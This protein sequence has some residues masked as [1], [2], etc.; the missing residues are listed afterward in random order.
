MAKFS[1]DLIALG[2]KCDEAIN[3]CEIERIE[4]CIQKLEFTPLDELE[5][6]VKYY[7]LGNL[8]AKKSCL[9]KESTCIGD[10]N[11]PDNL[12][13]AIKHYRESHKLAIN[14]KHL[15]IY[16]IQANLAI[17][18]KRLERQIEA[19]PLWIIDFS[20]KEGDSSFAG[21]LSKAN[22]LRFLS[23]YLSD[24]GYKYHYKFAAFEILDK[25]QDNIGNTTHEGIKNELNSKYNIEFIK[26][27]RSEKK[28]GNEACNMS[29]QAKST[30]K[31]KNGYHE[32][33]AARCLFLNSLN[34][35][36]KLP[37][38]ARDTLQFPNHRTKSYMP[39]LS[40]AF[41]A[42]KREYAFARYLVYEG[43][44]NKNC[45]KYE[46]EELYLTYLY[47]GT[48]YD[49]ASEKI[50]TAFRILFS[51]FDKLAGLMIQYFPKN[52]EACTI[53]RVEF[54]PKFIKKHFSKL[55]NPFITSLYWLAYDFCDEKENTLNPDANQLRKLRNN[56]EHNWV[57]VIE[58]SEDSERN[59]PAED[60]AHKITKLEL[61]ELILKVS[62]LARSS[63]M[64]FT[65]AVKY[66][67]K[68]QEQTE[69]ALL[70]ETPLWK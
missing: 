1:Y 41:S 34:D 44:H 17:C 37:I 66:N 29:Y 60:Y 16:E 36:T 33:C 69:P 15:L 31:A 30:S 6:A 13:I 12:I 19:L 9:Q 50:K 55:K 40:A 59:I 56:L 54:K 46:S 64:Y 52:N 49:T 24:A 28:K 63:L 7:Y 10:N 39:Y 21:S 42:L 3:S 57:R 20:T 61:Q 38:V 25:L 58:Y 35:I 45:P 32:W 65:F 51:I 68:R 62:G 48:C 70:M 4:L 22:T 23:D 11:T 14:N 53:K 43:I 67:E 27:W 2:E 18:L 26:Q 5:Q 47:D 8:Y